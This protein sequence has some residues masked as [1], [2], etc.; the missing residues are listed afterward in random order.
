MLYVVRLVRLVGT[1]AIAVVK[2]LFVVICVIMHWCMRS[3]PKVAV[4][5]HGK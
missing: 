5:I 2:A 1:S 4:T 3:V